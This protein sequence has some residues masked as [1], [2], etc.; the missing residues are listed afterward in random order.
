MKAIREVVEFADVAGARY[1]EVELSH[2][3]G[4]CI[5]FNEWKGEH[6]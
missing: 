4:D 1:G 3:K 6:A 5:P 2:T